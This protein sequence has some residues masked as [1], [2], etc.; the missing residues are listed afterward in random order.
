MSSGDIQGLR[1][2]HAKQAPTVAVLLHDDI[3]LLPLDK[4]LKISR[5]APVVRHL[6]LRLII[7]PLQQPR[8]H[9]TPSG[10]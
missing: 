6:V 2:A 5:L 10:R 3:E 8:V 9:Q 1:R 7:P 4:A